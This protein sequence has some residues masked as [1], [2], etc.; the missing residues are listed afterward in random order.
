[1]RIFNRERYA[2]RKAHYVLEAASGSPLG[3]SAIADE[4]QQNGHEDAIAGAEHERG[5]GGEE[6]GDEAGCL[7]AAGQHVEEKSDSEVYGRGDSKIVPDE[8]HSERAGPQEV[9]GW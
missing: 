1:M 7:D 8:G 9:V 2:G 4:T 6:T 5:V 3:D